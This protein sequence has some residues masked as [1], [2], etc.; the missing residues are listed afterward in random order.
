MSWAEV[1]LAEQLEEVLFGVQSFTQ[2]RVDGAGAVATVHVL[3]GR[4]LE[5]SMDS[6]GVHADGAAFDSVNSLL[7]NLSPKFAAAFHRSLAK[8]LAHAVEK[9]EAMDAQDEAEGGDSGGAG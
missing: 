1:E 6:R 9:R 5:L 3:E 7:L 8:H 4:A 2:V